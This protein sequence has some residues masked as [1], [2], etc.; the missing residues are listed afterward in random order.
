MPP[1]QVP[2]NL[3]AHLIRTTATMTH[4]LLRRP[5]LP[6]AL[7]AACLSF[8]GAL[9]A[10]YAEVG[11]AGSS[12]ATAQTTGGVAGQP[13]T[14]IT[15]TIGATADADFYLISIL[16]PSLFSAST[17]GGSAVDTQL[18]LFTFNGA[19]VYLNDDA[20]GA[21]T[22]SALPAGSVLGPQTAGTYILGIS[23]SGVDPVNSTNQTLFAPATFSTD[24]RGPASNTFGT[25]AGVFDNASFA[26]FGAYSI[27]LT[28]AVTAVPEPSTNALLAAGAVLVGAAALRR[29]RSAVR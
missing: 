23:V 29:R 2:V 7:S 17:V 14:T 28:G 13:L 26:D 8:T 19:P 27:A 5:A 15:G 21:S 3:A 12:A 20:N 6:M 24:V 1:G 16:S 18:Y 11:D 10:Q 22:Q 4:R 25:V 9:H